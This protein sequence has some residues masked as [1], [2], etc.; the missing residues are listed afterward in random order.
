MPLG[1]V[2]P[3]RVAVSPGSDSSGSRSGLRRFASI[4]G[5]EK[6]AKLLLIS[7]RFGERFLQLRDGDQTRGRAARVHRKDHERITGEVRQVSRPTCFVLKVDRGGRSSALRCEV[8][9][10]EEGEANDAQRVQDLIGSG[11]SG[12]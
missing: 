12:S 11:L 5:E 6:D 8:L 10:R 4:E 9:Q 1:T 2:A 7:G 3:C